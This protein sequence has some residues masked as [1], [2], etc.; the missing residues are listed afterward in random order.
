MV[1]VWTHTSDA[2]RHFC[3]KALEFAVVGSD[4]YKARKGRHCTNLLSI[5]RADLRNVGLGTLRTAKKIW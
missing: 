4:K 5:L 2:R 3:K 1:Y